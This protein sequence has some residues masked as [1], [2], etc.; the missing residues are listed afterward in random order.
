MLMLMSREWWYENGALGII[1]LICTTLSNQIIGLIFYKTIHTQE[2]VFRF[3]KLNVQKISDLIQFMYQGFVIWTKRAVCRKPLSLFKQSETIINTTVKSQYD[4]LYNVAVSSNRFVYNV[5]KIPYKSAEQY[6]FT[7]FFFLH[8][9]TANLCVL[10]TEH[11]LTAAFHCVCK[12]VQIRHWQVSK[13]K[14]WSFLKGCYTTASALASNISSWNRE[15]CIFQ[16][17]IRL[18]WHHVFMGSN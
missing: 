13:K 11:L 5:K 18:T 15:L 10:S 3:I 16:T 17:A 1:Y 7:V 14:I 2:I 6:V 9:Q 12:Q 8:T 4:L